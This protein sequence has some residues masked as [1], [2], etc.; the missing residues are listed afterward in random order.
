[1]ETPS[2]NS[3]ESPSGGWY[4]PSLLPKVSSAGLFLSST[5]EINVTPSQ[6]FTVSETHDAASSQSQTIVQDSPPINT[7]ALPQ[8]HSVAKRKRG[9]TL[10]HYEDS[11]FTSEDVG[12]FDLE[13]VV[14]K[15]KNRKPR[16]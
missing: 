7:K 5:L 10:S 3:A 15:S 14:A 1:M 13:V 8:S 9:V 4:L 11:E 2:L 6:T 16:Q 12:K